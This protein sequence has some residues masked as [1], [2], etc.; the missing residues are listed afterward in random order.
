MK[1]T[2]QN[3]DDRFASARELGTALARCLM[4][5]GASSKERDVTAAI[6][7]LLEREAEPAPPPPPASMAEA[8]PEAIDASAREGTDGEEALFE[9]EIL[10]ASGPIRKASE[11]SDADTI[12][13]SLPTPSQGIPVPRRPDGGSRPLTGAVPTAAISDRS[14]SRRLPTGSGRIRTGSGRVPTGSGPIPLADS[15]RVASR[16]PTGR[17]VLAWRSNASP[18]ASDPAIEAA[19]EHFDRGLA[20]RREG[21]FGEALA[22]WEQALAL[23]PENRIYQASVERLRGQ[24]GSVPAEADELAAETQRYD[25]DELDAG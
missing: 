25:L 9:M 13:V 6:S 1:A 24:L 11:V 2:A 23:A 4:E 15:G 10:E 19:V 8:V 12:R 5:V 3:P 16:Q 7:A 20:L 17:S 18:P 14:G 21:R 22:E